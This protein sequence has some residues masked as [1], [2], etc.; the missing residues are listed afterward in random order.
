[1]TSNAKYVSNLLYAYVLKA[2]AVIVKRPKQGWIKTK[3]GLML[4]C[5]QGRIYTPI[6]VTIRNLHQYSMSIAIV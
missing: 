5:K 1:M 6:I 3:L 2:D 4:R